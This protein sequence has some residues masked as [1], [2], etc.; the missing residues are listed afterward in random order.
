MK[1]NKPYQKTDPRIEEALF[2]HRS[3]KLAE[4]EEQIKK[5]LNFFPKNTQLLTHLGTIHLQQ[6]NPEEGV[7]ILSKSLQID[8]DQPM[9]LLN[10]SN[11]LVTLKRFQDALTSYDRTLAI[12]PDFAEAYYNRGEVLLGLN[13]PQDAAA[14]FDRAASL[15]P[16]FPGAYYNRGLALE[17]LGRLEES[18]ASF[19]RALALRPQY[20]EAHFNKGNILRKLG[21]FDDA[22]IEYGLSITQRPDHVES[23]TNQGY[24]LQ[25]LQRLDDALA[26][27]D[28]AIALQP[29]RPE[30][31][32]NRGTVL[33]KLKRLDEALAAHDRAIALHPGYAEAHNNR[34]TVLQELKRLDEALLAHD[35][36]ISLDPGYMEAY[37]NKALLKLLMGDYPEGWELY[38]K[39]AKPRRFTQ[40]L[41]NG[42]ESLRGKTI[43][44]HTE[45]GFGDVIQFSRYAPMLEKLGGLVLFEAPQAL[46]S[47]LSTLAGNITFIEAGKPL[48]DFDFYLPMMSLPSVF[49][50]TLE[51]IPA[52]VP[53]LFPPPGQ[54]DLWTEKLGKRTVPRIGLV[55]SG[56]QEHSNDHNRS[57]G[58]E[59]LAPLLKLPFEFH[60]LQKEYREKDK[61]LLAGLPTLKDHHRDLRDFSDTA[62]LIHEMDMV[63]SVDTSVAHLAG[64]MGK[65]LWV[66]LPYLPDYRWLLERSDSPWYPTATLFRQSKD[67]D[68]QSVISEVLKRMETELNIN[69]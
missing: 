56:K 44:V 64:A 11:G 20:P 39:R 66:L 7:R 19:D 12:K 40:P 13:R 38:E 16:D 59:N 1:T 4:A 28:R 9:A 67:G 52:E 8:P 3:G 25:D 47:V 50:T 15:H 6:G 57:I 46:V 41:W 63:L 55:W 61:A 37:W 30:A 23:Y 32:N 29:D 21:R 17:K 53:Y 24:V 62:G 58:L 33:R 60:S 31:H 5:L 51:T 48:P 26:S 42:T 49:Q 14:D 18:L 27:Y 36:A 54:K 10:R 45:Q 69:L 2:L 34:G 35:R 43:L 65:P 22:L 68:W